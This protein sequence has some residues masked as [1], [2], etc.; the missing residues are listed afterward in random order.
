MDTIVI[1]LLFVLYLAFYEPP[2][3]DLSLK[4]NMLQQERSVAALDLI[5]HPW[6]NFNF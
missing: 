3:V 2:K 1:T 5:Y 4:D 6:I